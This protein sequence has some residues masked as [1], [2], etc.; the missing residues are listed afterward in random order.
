MASSERRPWF[1]HIHFGAR[2]RYDDD[3]AASTKI[4]AVVGLKAREAE[5]LE[6]GV[7]KTIPLVVSAR[8]SYARRLVDIAPSPLLCI[9]QRARVKCICLHGWR[10]PSSW[11]EGEEGAMRSLMRTGSR[12]ARLWYGGRCLGLARALCAAVDAGRLRS[13]SGG[14]GW[15]SRVSECDKR[16]SNHEI[17]MPMWITSSWVWGEPGLA[18]RMQWRLRE[19]TRGRTRSGDGSALGNLLRVGDGS[20]RVTEWTGAGGAQ[21]KPTT[22]YRAKTGTAGGQKRGGRLGLEKVGASREESDEGDALVQRDRGAP[23]QL[24][25]GLED[26]DDT[27]VERLVQGHRDGFVQTQSHLAA[28]GWNLSLLLESLPVSRR[29]G[30]WTRG[31]GV[32]AMARVSAPRT[33]LASWWDTVKLYTDARTSRPQDGMARYRLAGRRTSAH[34]EPEAATLSLHERMA[35]VNPS[36]NPWPAASAQT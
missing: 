11:V 21:A 36:P 13:S 29:P 22:H 33:D 10:R 2:M 34:K 25:G 16:T 31:R 8:P 9:G 26:R 7:N 32:R 18:A 19:E 14:C 15:P 3:V 23:E 4:D 28:A 27:T 20:E 12:A 35:Y 24:Q 5:G 6:D 17:V 1:V 30:D